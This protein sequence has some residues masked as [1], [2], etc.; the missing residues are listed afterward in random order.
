MLIPTPRPNADGTYPLLGMRG[1]PPAPKIFVKFWREL[2]IAD[3]KPWNVVICG[4]D[5]LTLEDGTVLGVEDLETIDQ[6][7]WEFMLTQGLIPSALV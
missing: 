7:G 5:Q 1:G 3:C 6:A 2:K 4:E